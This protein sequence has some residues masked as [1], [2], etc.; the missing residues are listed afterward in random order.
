ML[1]TERPDYRRSKEEDILEGLRSRDPLALAEA[2]HRTSP[3]ANACGRRLL[4]GAVAAEALLSAVYADLWANPPETARLEGWVRSRCFRLASEH[5][6]ERQ[7]PAA[8]PSLALLLPDLPE[9]ERPS[10]DPVE[11]ALAE[12]SERE[13]RAL[14]LAHDQG[15]PTTAQEDPDAAGALERALLALAGP[16]SPSDSTVSQCDIPQMADWTLGLLEA[17]HAARVGE[18]VMNRRACVEQSQALRRGRRRLEGLP[19]AP[20][21]GQRVLANV[22]A[23]T[24]AATPG[25]GTPSAGAAAPARSPQAPS[26]TGPPATPAPPAADEGP[27]DADAALSSLDEAPGSPPRAPT[28]SAFPPPAPQPPAPQPPRAEPPAPEPSA[29]EPPVVEPPIPQPTAEPPTPEPPTAEPPAPG[30]AAPE[31]AAPTEPRIPFAPLP[32]ALDE[33]PSAGSRWPDEPAAPA[34]EDEDDSDAGDEA[35][36]ATAALPTQ[37]EGETDADTRADDVAVTDEDTRPN[38]DVLM[39]RDTS[40]A[41]EAREDEDDDFPVSTRADDTRT[42]VRERPREGKAP[43]DRKFVRQL[44]NVL[45]IVVV[46][47]AGGALGLLIGFLLIGGR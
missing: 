43:G 11:Q 14:L 42:E 3:A 45:A 32:S 34:P 2:Y 36:V 35:A 21:M 18:Q 29:A 5:L 4:G 33:E 27:R 23:G 24:P 26:D 30:R 1:R 41:E 39:D 19:P 47:A 40:T 22:L 13:R 7:E 8:A 17:D 16:G 28:P 44:L 12:L 38:E 31:Q 46:L 6:R 25:Q 9:P 37:E 10:H 15:M 20:D